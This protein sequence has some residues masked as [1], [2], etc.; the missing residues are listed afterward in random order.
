MTTR[1]R[2]WRYR[3]WRIVRMLVK[4]VVVVAVVGVLAPVAAA[5]VAFSTL[6]LLPLPGNLPPER[7]V[8]AGQ[9]SHVYDPAGNV[10]GTFRQ[11]ESALPVRAE[12]I[13]PVLVDALIASEDRNFYGHNGV[14]FEALVRAAWANWRNDSVVQ[15]GST[16]TQQYVKNTYTGGERS[17]SRKIREAV[18]AARL[19]RQLSKE[20]ILFRY[21]N[22]VYLGEGAYGVGAAAQTY[23][24]K[25]VQLLTLS[26]AAL[27]VGIVPAPSRYS[28]RDNPAEAEAR[29]VAVLQDMYE[30]G[31]ISKDQL[32]AAVP[33][34]V[35]LMSNGNP[36]GP[37]TFVW[38]AEANG[39][40]QYPYFVDYVRRYVLATYGPDLVYRGG[41]RIE[42][43]IDPNLQ[44]LAEAEV[45]RSLEGTSSPLEM[46]LVSVD[47]RTGAV[48]A[49]VGGRDWAASQVNLALGGSTGFQPGSSFKPFVLATAFEGGI[50]PETVYN[51]PG[52]WR[53]PGC[54]GNGCTIDNYDHAGRGSL[55]LRRAMWS[56][57]N[58]VYA[59]L[60]ND[61]GTQQTAA[62]ANR[63][64][65]TSIDPE[66]PYGLTLALGSAEVTP[67]DMA[68]A[69][70]VFANHGVRARATPVLRVL[71]AQG[72][73][74]ED[75]TQPH[76]EQVLDPAVADT[77]TDVLTGVIAGGT[78]R[79]AAIG[80][81]AAGKTG[82]A[83]EYRAAWFVGYTP[84]LSTAVWIGY[85][86]VQRSLRNI[87]GVGTVTGG[88]IPAAT[89]SR[90][91]R[92]ALTDQPV[93]QFVEPGPLPRLTPQG[94]FGL[95]GGLQPGGRR[96]PLQTPAD[97]DGPCE[98]TPT[99][100]LPAPSTT[101]TS[102]TT[103]TTAPG[104][105][106]GGPTSSTSNPVSQA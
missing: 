89:W 52:S 68:A 8:D 39:A 1:G 97:C 61:V 21:L 55:T 49:L 79:R 106:G 35:W 95:G 66:Q 34:Q 12:D 63:M 62:L 6:V 42:A 92:A 37:A 102:S 86:D 27:L 28:P 15:G 70:G 51:A 71:D 13:P 105:S 41:L 36:P 76:G 5:G 81:P 91:M 32:D 33:E 94:D 30:T 43:S 77:V 56:S 100:Q 101:T 45:A 26:E 78:G 72:N 67:L 24:R 22:T 20:E 18:L 104:A 64:G 82:T 85:S 96:S 93:E 19:E 46:S 80:R 84:Q 90:F 65:L 31:K 9:P 60:I 16:I 57:I 23:F 74:L 3:T 29:R 54:Q 87:G 4:T 47:P 11:F 17:L 98:V 88:T 75:N 40:A 69:Y 59:Q 103:S 50:G 2:S 48:R 38:P 58:T 25:P 73:V 99:L 44:Q 7:A 83:E 53:V 14:D 10:I